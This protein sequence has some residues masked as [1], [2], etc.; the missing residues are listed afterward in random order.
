MDHSIRENYI[1]LMILM[2][3]FG[4]LANELPFSSTGKYMAGDWNG[5]RSELKN[6][7]YDFTLE[8]GSM[9]TSNI[10]GG[11]NKDRT[12]RY[13]DQY[14]IGADFDLQ[15]IAGITDGEFKVSVIDRN[16]RDLTSDRIQ[17]PRAPVIG[18]TVNSNYGRGQIWHAAQFWYRQS[19]YAKTID[20]KLGLMPVGEDFDNNGCYFQNLSLCGSLAG[21][22]AGV[23][24][25]TPIGQWG[26]RLRYNFTP[27]VY[28]QTGAFM[29]NPNYATRSGSFQLDNTGRLGNMYLMEFGYTPT[30]GA[31]K[32]PGAWKV[33]AW[34]NTAKASD[35]LK[36]AEGDDYVTSQRPPATHDGRYGGWIYLLQQVTVDPRSPRGGLSLF[37]HLAMNDRDTATMDYQTQ[38]G[39]IYKGPFSGRG[40]DY[41]GFGV[42]K[43]H[44][45]SKVA[46]RAQ[47]LNDKKGLDDYDNPAWTPVRD[48]EYAAELHYSFVVTPWLTLRPNVQ[49]LID[50]GGVSE[51]DDAWV[52]GTQITIKL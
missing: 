24:Y 1:F 41:I 31:N 27:Q 5:V 32:L 12:A 17:D 6:K 29:Y 28:L 48:A 9:V 45:N 52:V 10:S 47:L 18:S 11:Y 44:E 4:S 39:A 33:G 3:P 42:S 22:G 13:S 20:L 46:R 38:I 25:N 49:L 7:G 19:W 40:Q 36:D 23:W 43:M 37:W 50:P 34:Y 30:L 14:I 51:I 35:V 8:Y 2:F 26:A 15:K 16:G 21:H